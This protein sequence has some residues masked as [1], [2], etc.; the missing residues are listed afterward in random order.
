MFTRNGIANMLAAFVTEVAQARHANPR[1]TEP[2]AGLRRS[3][4]GGALVRAA[5]TSP[6]WPRLSSSASVIMMEWQHA[7][8]DRV[9]IGKLVL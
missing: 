4:R 9:F 5:A 6:Y 7:E 2:M 3:T 8:E 1:C